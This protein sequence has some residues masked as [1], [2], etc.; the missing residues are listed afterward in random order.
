MRVIKLDAIDST[1]DFL[2]KIASQQYLENYVVVTAKNQTNGKGQMG[3]KWTSEPGKNLIFSILIKDILLNINEIYQLNIA[4]SLSIIQVLESYKIPKL[5]IKWPND[6]MTDH[7]KLGGIL[8][9]NSIKT[10]GEIISIAGI[11]LNVNQNNFEDLPRATS[12]T[13]AKAITFDIDEILYCI[14]NAIQNNM[15][16]ILNNESKQLWEE[17]NKYLFKKGIPMAF[18][19]QNGQQFMGIIQQVNENGKLEMLLEDDTIVS[20]EI[21]E[22]QMLY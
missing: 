12:L 17:Y 7:K 3:A 1:N 13:L 20:F 22:I 2:K 14:I 9:E 4:V 11:G 16:R 21:K 8:I 19:N 18:E 6:I 15:K 10:D 5:S